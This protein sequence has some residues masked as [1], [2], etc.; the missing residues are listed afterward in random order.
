MGYVLSV[1]LE[2]MKGHR[3]MVEANVRDEK[4]AC[5]II[6]LPD[7]PMKESKDRI[8]SCLNV[9]AIDISLKRLTIHLSPPDKRK[10]GTGHDC[11]MLLAVLKKLE[12]EPIPIDS[13]T[14][15]LA[16]LSLSGELLPFHGLIPAIQQAV[17]L[18]FK[19][20]V[21]P[22]IDTSYLQATPNVE[23]VPIHSVKDLLA[24]LRGQQTISLPDV[25][26]HT[27]STDGQV[28]ED[29]PTADFSAVRGHEEAKRV[30]EIAAAGGHHVLL[31]GPPGCG[32]TL[33][34]DAFHTIL[35][36]LS[37]ESMLE[38]YGIYHLAQE[39]RGFS[40][41]PPYRAPHHSASSVSL[42]GGGTFPRPGEISLAHQGVLF[43]DE[44]GEFSRKTLDML[45][46]P[47]E[48]GEVTINRVRQSVTY[49]SAFILVAA[50]NPCPCGYFGSNEKYCTCTPAQIRSYQLKASGPLL[51][52]ID[53]ILTLK[54]VGVFN[55]RQAESSIVIR[56]RVTVAREIQRK[57]Y[58]S[59]HLN[60][61]VPV[62]KLMAATMLSDEQER[63]IQ[64]I[65]F[66]EKW[67]NRTMVKL[68]RVARTIADLAGEQSISE[69][70]IS[71]AIDCL[72]IASAIHGNKS[73][74]V[75]GG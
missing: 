60:G 11:A 58:S 34:A 44:L 65:C 12:L 31:N 45:R 20:I 52:R 21:I 23:F 37:D 53:F 75:V 54:S 62:S 73:E 59:V 18:G 49:P 36:D 41:R 67:S 74:V 29:L 15:F 9:L 5:V 10:S 50:T 63:F 26:F 25:L 38:T 57:R 19:R 72:R 17:V 30:M 69:A 35:P 22:P 4:E 46:Q 2:G 27:V 47:M 28:D 7:A 24:Y 42:I 8:L 51:N 14:C 3:V 61:N 33:L 66:R 43:L 55:N 32:K 48:S 39:E 1:G 64:S 40:K 16:A 70:S 13:E 71:E 6:G 68:I 56:E